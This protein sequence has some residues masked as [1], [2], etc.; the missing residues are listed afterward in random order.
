MYKRQAIALGKLTM[1]SL[2]LGLAQGALEESK[3]FV[4]TRNH[5]DGTISKFMNIK[6]KL[7]DI[8]I[9]V[10]AARWLVYRLGFLVDEMKD[11]TLSLIHIYPASLRYSALP[12]TDSANHQK[13]IGVVRN[14]RSPTSGTSDRLSA[15]SVIDLS[16]N[17]RSVCSGIGDRFG[18]EYANCASVIC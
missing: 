8:A 10:E 6:M 13:V 9:K 3:R 17:Q 7:A 11:Y 15:E 14:R 4:T 2:F 1:S 5:R 16:R 12:I 18:A